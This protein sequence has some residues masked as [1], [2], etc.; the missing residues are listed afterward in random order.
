M[1]PTLSPPDHSNFMVSLR[2]EIV[3]GSFSDWDIN[4]VQ[5]ARRY[6]A[7]PCRETRLSIL[8]P[9]RSPTASDKISGQTGNQS[10]TPNFRRNVGE[11]RV[12]SNGLDLLFGNCVQWP[13]YRT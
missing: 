3:I 9:D 5:K 4:L 10:L 12:L 6:A 8:F 11:G 7:I 2:L 1:W 13:M